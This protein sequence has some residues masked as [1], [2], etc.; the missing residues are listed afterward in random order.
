MTSVLDQI[1]Q[2]TKVVADTD[3]FEYAT[4][5]LS[6]ILQVT[7]KPNYAHL[8]DSAIKYAK[9]KNGFDN[10]ILKIIPGRVSTEADAIL[11]F[12]TEGTVAK[13]NHLIGLYEEADIGKERILIKIASTWEGIKACLILEKERI[14]FVC[15]EAG[16]TLVSPFVGRILDWYKKNT[17][18][19]FSAKEDPGEG[20][21]LAG[22]DLL[23]IS[24][25][26][27]E[28]L[29]SDTKKTIKCNLS[30]ENVKTSY[31]EKVTFDE[32]GFRW[33]L[34]EDAMATE[35]LAEDI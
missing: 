22:C 17:G 33:A 20:K 7:Q 1:K 34:N 16:I 8:V 28:Q 35:K 24:P 4:T 9:S 26:L 2:Y 25:K 13:A 27:L 23:I 21:E 29:H 14:H 10:E 19:D 15:A 31:E 11:S 12:D 30:P 6:L 3:Y 32:K 18:R 5:N